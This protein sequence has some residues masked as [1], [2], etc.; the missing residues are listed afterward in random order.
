MIAHLITLSDQLDSKG[1]HKE[2][3]RIDRLI[4]ESFSGMDAL[5]GALDLAGFIPGAGEIFDVANAGIST[6][7]GDPIGAVLSAISVIP[8]IG[9]GIG[10]SI[11]ALRYAAKSGITTIKWGAKTFT[12]QRLGEWIL[13]EIESNKDKIDLANS[14]LDKK[15]NANTFSESWRVI[16]NDLSAIATSAPEQQGQQSAMA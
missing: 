13:D 5:Q 4:K 14:E 9:D 7:R 6:L 1:L 11:K 8:G 12:L 3:D 2:A 16:S 15:V 10:K